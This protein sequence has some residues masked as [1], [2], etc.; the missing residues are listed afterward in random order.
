MNKKRFIALLTVVATVLCTIFSTPYT[1]KA[2][3]YQ[4]FPDGE[5]ASAADVLVP[6]KDN[7]KGIQGTDFEYGQYPDENPDSLGLNHIL[8]NIE[9]DK[10]INTDGSGYPYEYNGKTYYFN[11]SNYVMVFERR[12]QEYREKGK[13]I[14]LVLLLGWSDDPV[15]NNLIYPG[16]R[17][18]DGT[19]LYYALNSSDTAAR[20]QLDATFHFLAD[21]FGRKHCFVQNWILGN[22]VN[23]PNEYNYCGTADLTTNVNICAASFDILYKALQDKNP[24]AKAYISLT[25]HWN[26]D[27]EGRGM[28]TKNF[29]D[30]FAAKETDK[31]WN[32]AFHAY[33]PNLN[34][35]CWSKKAA[36][37]LRHDVISRYVCGANLE[38]LTNYVKENYGTSHRIILSEQGFNAL[39]GQDEQ[40][41]MMVYTY[42]AAQRDDMVDA[43]IF[44]SWTDGG[45]SLRD[46]YQLGFLDSQGNKRPIYYA[47]KYMDTPQAATYTDK[48]LSTIGI[49]AWTDNMI[50]TPEKTDAVIT[51]TSLYVY[52][53]T[54][55]YVKIGMTT[56]TSKK[57]DVE[58]K[59]SYV[60]SNNNTAV[61]SDWLLNNE[62]IVWTP[63]VN[64]RYEVI[65]E[66]RVA[67]NQN[68]YV[69]NSRVVYYNTTT[70]ATLLGA[71][72][73]AEYLS[74]ATV[75]LKMNA[76]TSSPAELEY[77]WT[78]ID[79][80]N[81]IIPI[82]SWDVNASSIVWTPGKADHY[83]VVGNVRVAA[84]QSSS[85]DIV[86]YVDIE[87]DTDNTPTSPNVTIDEASL[88]VAENNRSHILVGM[89]TKTSSSTT[90][91]YRWTATNADGAK[92]TVK[93]WTAGNEWLDWIPDTFGEY[94]LTGEARVVGNPS[95]TKSASEVVY[96]NPNIKGKCQLPYE[97]VAPGQ[98]GYLIGV[99]TY[100]NPNQEYQYEM[101][102]LNCT[103]M[104]W[105]YSTG[106]F[107]VSDGAAGWCVWQPEYG[108]YWTLFRVYD[109]N[110]NMIDQACY[111]FVNAY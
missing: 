88:Y 8:L 50:Y 72:I 26:Y 56:E 90:L 47:F 79:S 68:S 39:N 98:P 93:D 109:K 84:N 66:A 37:W 104:A 94:T 28:S 91:E 69:K 53:N 31:N 62:W 35:V 101:L 16:G 42:Y 59:W 111:G 57:T 10:V 11:Y 76:S 86:K 29:I 78:A 30:A 32:I 15:I 65:A 55:T 107:T 9:L 67:A 89:V 2:I 99:E 74:G 80:A 4:N 60:D 6:T 77:Q 49:S 95:V 20:E 106:K 13:A 44:T 3:S 87:A 5:R 83:A 52:E 18:N 61:I 25:D 70:D 54:S 21:V 63:P 36:E 27:D 73:D 33:P 108:Y 75:R 45:V 82:N 7:K 81:N 85:L 1:V 19:H 48:Y 58:Y 92:F 43:V 64:G 34:E 103:S 110:G 23:M 51:Q 102:I 14:S 41:A 24:N 105:V 100:E 22:E 97:M 71:S 40:A 38:V 96:F 46:G 12:I 17:V